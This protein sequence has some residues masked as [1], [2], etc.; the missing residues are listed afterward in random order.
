MMTS[1]VQKGYNYTTNFLGFNG[2]E[3]VMH[4]AQN[5]QL[6]ELKTVEI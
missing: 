4:A 6:L 1:N 2:K 3:L 5:L